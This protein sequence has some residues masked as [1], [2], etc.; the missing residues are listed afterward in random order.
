MLVGSDTSQ[1]WTV[2]YTACEYGRFK[3]WDDL[4]L[5]HCALD[6]TFLADIGQNAD[7]GSP[8]LNGFIPSLVTHGLI[9]SWRH[10]R[11]ALGQEHL[12]FQGVPAYESLTQAVGIELPWR[13]Q[14]GHLSQ[15]QL[16]RLAGNAQSAPLLGQQLLYIISRMRMRRL[17]LRAMPASNTDDDVE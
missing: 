11:P 7:F 15:N 5:R 13:S 2:L 10:G 6:G 12:V 3:A 4:R 8:P 16:V 17:V 1:D 14:L 9:H